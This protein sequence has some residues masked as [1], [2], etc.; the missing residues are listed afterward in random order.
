M[1]FCGALYENPRL[2]PITSASA[3]R[4]AVPLE[5]DAELDSLESEHL[6]AI[7]M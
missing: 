2:G 6:I 4:K 1:V 3:V 5:S 7:V